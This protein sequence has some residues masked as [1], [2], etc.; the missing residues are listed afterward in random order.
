M[1][2][3]V[4]FS[5]N[6]EQLGRSGFGFIIM[7]LGLMGLVFGTTRWEDNAPLLVLSVVV[8]VPMIVIGLIELNKRRRV[9]VQVVVDGAGITDVRLGPHP[10]PWAEVERCE[11]GRGPKGSSWLRLIL[12]P[13]SEAERRLGKNRVNIQD[14]TLTRGPDGVR[15]AIAR[16]APQVSRDW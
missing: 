14:A 3:R 16:L 7:G 13:G 8:G 1:S 5:Y 15:K 10:I 4:E 11:W 9:G 6:N 2:E 12:R